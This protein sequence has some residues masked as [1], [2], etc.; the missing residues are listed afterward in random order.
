[1]LSSSSNKQNFLDRMFSFGYKNTN[2]IATRVTQSTETALDLCFTNCKTE[3][4]TGVL[5]PEVSDHL[6]TFAF[7]TWTVKQ[8]SPVNHNYH[9]KINQETIEV[10]KEV[11]ADTNWNSIFGYTDPV[12]VYDI[13]IAKLTELTN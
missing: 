9:Q 8:R 3:I 6:P 1:M 10:F 2:N 4:C 12:I 13:F 5:T 7:L 11:V